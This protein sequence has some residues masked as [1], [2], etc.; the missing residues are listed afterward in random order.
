[1]SSTTIRVGAVTVSALVL[2]ALAW[3]RAAGPLRD[4]H[5][6]LADFYE[7]RDRAE[8]QLRDPLILAG[9]D[10][11][12]LVIEAV[13]DPE[14]R[15]RRYA[16]GYLGI[17]SDAEAV[18]VLTQI[19]SDESEVYYFRSD[20]LE[21]LQRIDPSV[22]AS[23]APRYAHRDDLLGKVAG[24]IASGSY[25]PPPERTWWEAFFSVHH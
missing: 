7:A 16:I 15:L 23:F 10:V 5:D 13:Y 4:P 14:M 1:M 22:A 25:T 12:P 8:D 18:P 17:A 20:A 24:A 2:L 3:A 9:P 6:A 21:A 19:L 11:V